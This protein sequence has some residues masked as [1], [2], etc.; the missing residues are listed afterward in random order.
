MSTDRVEHKATAAVGEHTHLGNALS[1]VN[2]QRQLDHIQSSSK[3][4]EGQKNFDG[5][6]PQQNGTIELTDPFKKAPTE[7][8]QKGL[9]GRD[10][11]AA[12]PQPSFDLPP[13]GSDANPPGTSSTKH[14]RPTDAPASTSPNNTGRPTEAPAGTSPDN[15]SRP[16]ESPSTSPPGDSKTGLPSGK[17]LT[18]GE[19]LTDPNRGDS[20][21]IR[22]NWG[23]RNESGR[24]LPPSK[25]GGIEAITGQSPGS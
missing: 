4:P 12:K 2:Q 20:W 5:Q 3:N 7:A 8:T 17:T 1:E 15:S 11:G 23:L 6:N 13:A 19:T 25:S 9:N 21:N 10:L 16:N 18:P 22:N 14:L 24:P